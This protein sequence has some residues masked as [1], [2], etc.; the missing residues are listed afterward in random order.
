M[1]PQNPAPS[2]PGRSVLEAVRAAAPTADPARIR[3]Q[4]ALFLFRG[5]AVHQPVGTLSGGEQRRARL[6][7][8]L[9]ADPAPQLLILDEPTDDLDFAGVRHLVQALRAHQ[10]AL[11]VVS[12]DEDFLEQLA[13]DRRLLLTREGV[14]ERGGDDAAS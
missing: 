3:H 5:E 10:G 6:A 7:R 4:L 14:E 13:L 9:L 1:L 11:L 2:D 12:H 8:L